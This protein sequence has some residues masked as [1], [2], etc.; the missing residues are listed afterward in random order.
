MGCVSDEGM[1]SGEFGAVMAS[2]VEV[3]AGEPGPGVGGR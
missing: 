2:A 3:L 1:V